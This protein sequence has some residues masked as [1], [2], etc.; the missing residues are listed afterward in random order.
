M[1]LPTELKEKLITTVHMFTFLDLF[2]YCYLA[3]QV[4]SVVGLYSYIN[5]QLIK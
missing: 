1:K 3:T 4:Y 2:E 5:I